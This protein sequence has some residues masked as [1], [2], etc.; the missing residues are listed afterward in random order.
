MPAGHTLLSL[1]TKPP[2]RGVEVSASKT[3]CPPSHWACELPFPALVPEGHK[4][5]SA[6]RPYSTASWW[7]IRRETGATRTM[8]VH[9]CSVT[10]TFRQ[11]QEHTSIAETFGLLSSECEKEAA[12]DPEIGTSRA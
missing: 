7:Y 3:C 5:V 1:T 8:G 4:A 6:G 11:F 2:I 12:D 9:V 10:L